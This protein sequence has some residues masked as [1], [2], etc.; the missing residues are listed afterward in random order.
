V[1]KRPD[2]KKLTIL[3]I[4]YPFAPVRE[5]TAGGA[6]QILALIDEALVH[7]GHNSIVIA[8][9]GSKTRGLL[10]PAGRVDRVIDDRL[11]AEIHAIYR[12]RIK[13]VLESIRIDAI[14]MHGLDFDSYMP[15]FNETR[16]V[17][18]LATLH[19]PLSWYTERALSPSRERV[20]LN[21]VSASQREIFPLS[22]RLKFLPDIENGVPVEKFF[23]L[24]RKRNYALALGRICP[25][26]GFHIA[27]EA[28]G[29]AGVSLI[30]AGQVFPY[31][32]HQKYFEKNILPS[33]NPRC[34]F[35][36]PVDFARKRRLLAGARCLLSPSLVPETSGLTAREAMAS[37]TPVIAFPS[38][39]LAD[40]VEDGK[41]GFFVNNEK[42]IAEAI[43]KAHLIDP[44]T[45]R[46]TARER[47]SADLMTAKYIQLYQKLSDLRKSP[48]K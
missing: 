25:E 20:Y 6:E 31:E 9:K 5:D 18:V 46:R 29:R 19:L 36:G 14:H 26:K 12:E 43:R 40:T 10:I 47:F 42:E 21:C 8:T 11:R 44:E 28:A 27:I 13:E 30:I 37:G 33:L 17:P 23:L 32:A 34:K 38:G 39:A 1:F 41:T 7:E 15:P 2:L 35:T 22:S 48:Y 16:P 4:A 45:C 24:I 3:N